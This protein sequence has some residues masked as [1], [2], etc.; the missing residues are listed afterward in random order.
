VNIATMIDGVKS[1]EIEIIW[2]TPSLTKVA[3]YTSD[4]KS[5]VVGCT[6]NTN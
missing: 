6:C 5:R 4:E 2:D 1:D 3:P